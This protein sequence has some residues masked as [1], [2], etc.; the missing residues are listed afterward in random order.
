MIFLLC[1]LP[2]FIVL[3]LTLRCL[4]HF[5]LIFCTVWV[6]G[7]LPFP[8]AFE[9]PVFPA[10][11]VKKKKKTTLSLWI[12]QHLCKLCPGDRGICLRHHRPPLRQLCAARLEIRKDM[13]S[14]FML[15]FKTCFGCFGSFT[16]PYKFY[17]YWFL[18]EKR[19]VFPGITWSLWITENRHPRRGSSHP[20]C[21]FSVYLGLISPRTAVKFPVCRCH[22]YFVK[23]I[24][25]CL[26]V[27]MLLYYFN[28]NFWL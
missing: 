16:L 22:T 25:K 12:P 7:P 24:S 1:F 6:T 11:F 10:S 20:W 18:Q 3:A 4:I 13:L 15:P 28:S 27:L 2:C 8:L 5:G 9:N 23:S 17:N 26:F 19:A 14:D 21:I